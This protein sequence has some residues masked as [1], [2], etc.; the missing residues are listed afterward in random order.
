MGFPRE[1]VAR[2]VPIK[3]MTVRIQTIRVYSRYRPVT[4]IDIPVVMTAGASDA[5]MGEQTP[6]T[7]EDAPLQAWK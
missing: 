2:I 6:D 3:A 7:T 1:P 4:L 5:N